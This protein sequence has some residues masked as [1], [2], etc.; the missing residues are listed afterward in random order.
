MELTCISKME[1]TCI[2]KV[3]NIRGASITGRVLCAFDCSTVWTP[4]LQSVS[5]S[6]SG[7][8]C[9]GSLPV[10]SASLE[11]NEV[12]G[13]CLFSRLSD[14]SQ[15]FVPFDY[16]SEVFCSKVI[17]YL[18]VSCGVEG[19]EGFGYFSISI[20]GVDSLKF[21]VSKSMDTSAYPSSALRLSR[22]CVDRSMARR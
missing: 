1:L 2:S 4:S 22:D 14:T 3:P 8:V 19:L 12:R 16:T 10:D 11:S 17:G 7:E 21:S 20:T 18:T 6:Q 5:S 9:T 13:C 15:E